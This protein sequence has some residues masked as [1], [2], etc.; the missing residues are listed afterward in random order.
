MIVGG[1]IVWHIHATL[2]EGKVHTHCF[3][4]ARVLDVSVQIPTI[5]RSDESVGSVVL[6]AGWTTPSCGRWRHWRGISGAWSRWYAKRG[7]WPVF[8]GTAVLPDKV[9]RQFSTNWARSWVR[10]AV[11][12]AK[13]NSMPRKEILCIGTSLLFP[14]L[15]R[16]PNWLRCRKVEAC[17][18]I[19]DPPSSRSLQTNLGDGHTRNAFC[20]NILNGSLWSVRIKTCR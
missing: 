20:D 7:S 17:S 6:H 4:G 15:N 1:S 3:P 16:K 9:L 5:L 12:L 8:I 14:L 10:R 18:D 11:W 13:S 19:P 2:A